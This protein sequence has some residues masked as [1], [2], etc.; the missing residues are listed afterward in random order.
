[1]LAQAQCFEQS[2]VSSDCSQSDFPCLCADTEFMTAVSGCQTANCTV[3]ETLSAFSPFCPLASWPQTAKAFPNTLFAASTNATVALC[4]IPQN[5][6]SATIVG[7]PAS[8]G[9]LALLMVILRVV[10]RIWSKKV[11]LGWDD[12]SVVTAMLLA[13]PLN[14]LCFAMAHHGMGKDLWTLT[15]PNITMTL[16]LL[17]VTEIFYMPA[18]MFVQLSL[19]AF[20]IRVF[21]EDANKIYIKALIGI[22]AAFGIA[23]TFTLVFQCTP[24]PYFWTSW[25][26]DQVGHCININLFSWIRAAI[27]IAIDVVIIVIP[28][29]MLLK[30]HMNWRK[31]LQV[32]AMFSVGFVYVSSFPSAHTARF[33]NKA[34]PSFKGD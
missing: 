32:M 16:K 10:D 22:V 15:F 14:F 30:L 13:L 29:P 26:G 5:D 9:S 25:T 6:A 4:D 21:V 28:L 7:I 33:T 17:Y 8:F 12:Y 2:L 31:K 34:F 3:K 24:V 20:Y 1:M 27:E 19:L 23:N 18:E 11:G